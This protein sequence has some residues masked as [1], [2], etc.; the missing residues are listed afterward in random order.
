MSFW[1]YIPVVGS[2]I[3][4]AVSSAMNYNNSKKLA[5]YQQMLNQESIDTQNRYNLPINQMSRLREAGLNPNLVYGNGSVA[6]ITSDAA[7]VSMPHQQ[8][9]ETG[10]GGAIDAFFKSQSIGQSIQESK[11]RQAL[12]ETQKQESTAR[13]HMYESNAQKTDAEL[14]Y[15]DRFFQQRLSNMAADETYKIDAGYAQRMAGDLSLWRKGEVEE[16]IKLL[17]QKTG[18]TKE[19]IIT[20]GVKR[21]SMY[22]GMILNGAVIEKI[23]HEIAYIDKGTDLRDLAYR[24][25]DVDFQGTKLGNEWLADHPTIGTIENL[26]RRV[27]E[28]VGKVFGGS[29][30]YKVP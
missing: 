27:L 20:E 29:V 24:M 19:Q 3:D 22:S 23:S 15:L 13:A 26:V 9:V 14:P 5:R 30:S 25:Q 28:D 8:P 6:G 4:G 10:I 2:L 12:L 1:N 21:S 11:A 17:Q 18:L 16:N 7:N